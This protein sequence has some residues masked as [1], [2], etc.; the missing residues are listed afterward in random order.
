MGLLDRWTKKKQ[1]ET[2][3]KKADLAHEEKVSE[4]KSESKTEKKVAKK[5]EIGFKV[6]VR[7]LITEKAANA[8]SQNKYSF[9]VARSASKL[10][11]K[12]AITEVYGVKPIAVNVQ[13]I[14]GKRVRFGRSMGQ[15]QDYKKAIITLPAG[16]SIVIH[17]G[18]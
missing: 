8:Q 18:V 16:K 12:Q 11:I 9:I 10:Q 15:R 3:E 6:L 7:P 5:S 1:K 13:N 14:S 17:E 2:L 4:K